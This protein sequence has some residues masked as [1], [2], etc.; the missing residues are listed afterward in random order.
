M[1]LG[2]RDFLI[3]FPLGLAGLYFSI[4][5]LFAENGKTPEELSE[6]PEQT[7][8]YL[9]LNGKRTLEEAIVIGTD[10]LDN[11]LINKIAEEARYEHSAL[12][13]KHPFPENGKKGK[14]IYSQTEIPENFMHSQVVLNPE[15]LEVLEW[16]NVQLETELN[17][18]AFHWR[19]YQRY[20]DCRVLLADFPVI[21]G[22]RSTKTPVGD[23]GIYEIKHFPS[24]SLEGRRASPGS[25]KNPLGEW[26]FKYIKNSGMYYHG[27][28]EEYL[29][30]EQN[31]ALSHGCVRNYNWNVSKL[32]MLVLRNL[33]KLDEYDDKR[34][35]TRTVAVSPEIPAK[36]VYDTIEVFSDGNVCF[37]PDVYS[38]SS[39]NDFTRLTNW[40]HLKQDIEEK[41][42]LSDFDEVRLK[43]QV[44]IAKN[45]TGRMEINLADYVI[46][47]K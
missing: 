13:E 27:T 8:V 31:R 3:R 20:N 6:H 15:N 43:Q 16:P 21:V 19:I 12:R 40:E 7:P 37:Y 29:L 26:E 24:W 46:N 30:G 45:I 28:N 39:E 35:S 47:K 38:Y 2:R 44:K 25:P 42:S 33:N 36:N 17:I 41:F 10:L 18:P 23:F 4:D 9:P 11:D 32:A 5:K 22:K 1:D 34:H 14:I